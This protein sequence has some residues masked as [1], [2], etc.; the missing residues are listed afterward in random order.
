M[1]YLWQPRLRNNPSSPPT[2]PGGRGTTPQMRGHVRIARTLR[3]RF[4]T[5]NRSRDLD[6]EEKSN[7]TRIAARRSPLSTRTPPREPFAPLS[8]LRGIQH[9]DCPDLVRE[10]H[11]AAGYDCMAA[12]QEDKGSGR[13]SFDFNVIN[14]HL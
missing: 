10:L 4:S 3:L 11:N 8:L 9:L 12:M 1:P 6:I 14:R 5:P 2:F 13:I 7:C